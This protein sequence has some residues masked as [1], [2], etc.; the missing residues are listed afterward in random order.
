MHKHHSLND[1]R[2]LDLGTVLLVREDPSHRAVTPGARRSVW[3][4]GQDP[5]HEA[6]RFA[7][8]GES[9]HWATTLDDLRGRPRD[10]IEATLLD[11]LRFARNR[12]THGSMVTTSRLDRAYYPLRK[13][14][15]DFDYVWRRVDELPLPETGPGSGPAAVKEREAYARAWQGQ[16]VDEILGGC[17]GSRGIWV[18]VP[19]LTPPVG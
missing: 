9:L 17:P 1:P 8:I 6:A 4:C 11:A 15:R 14:L 16:R 3:L 7:A 12:A 5:D 19:R 18:A 13:P 2:Q 10:T